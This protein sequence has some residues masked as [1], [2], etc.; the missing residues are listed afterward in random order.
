MRFRLPYDEI[1]AD[2]ARG[3]TAVENDMPSLTQQSFRD[4]ADLN[5]LLERFGVREA[6]NRIVPVDPRFYGDFSNAV[7]LRDVL[8]VAREAQHHFMDLPAKLRERF[9]NDPA[10]LWE[11]VND[12][13]NHDECVRLGLLKREEAPPP[14]TVTEPVKPEAPPAG[15]IT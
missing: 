5:V 7:D 14:V 9:Q 12:R 3:V 8:D 4:D 10:K 6:M 2:K 15:G 11:F 13:D 1:E